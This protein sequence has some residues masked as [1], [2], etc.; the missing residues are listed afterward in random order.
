LNGILSIKIQKLNYLI[1]TFSKAL[2]ILLP[3]DENSMIIH[4]GYENLSLKH[5]FVTVGVFDGVHKGHRAL[6][7]HLAT[8]AEEAGGESVVITF[9][10]HPR[11][12]LSKKTEGIFFLSTLDEKKKLL[13]ESAIDHLI[14]MNFTRELGNMEAADFIKEILV[15]KIG[16]K[17]LIVGY[18][19][20]FGKGKEGD[21]EKI[22]EYAGLYDF[23]AEQADGLSAPEGKISSTIIR[24]A[25][26]NGRLEDANR[27]LGYN[28]SLTGNVIEGRK[29]GRSLGFPTANI[30]PADMFKLIPADGVYA[31]EV[32]TGKEKLPGMLSIGFNPTV[33]KN[34][35]DKSVEVHIFDFDKEL[36][37][38]T[39]TVIF[40][41]RL[42]DEKRFENTEQLTGQMK[43]DKES[44]MRLL[45]EQHH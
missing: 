23:E 1:I 25:L 41:F 33:N 45:A 20:H 7:D 9:D 24:D 21:F 6:L 8:R 3:Q 44:V 43:L 28:Y 12:V 31:V 14:I 11:L 34:R 18:D 27:L 29:L 42:R 16:V 17:H 26:L 40:R 5:P 4:E 15:E 35:A 13:A 32:L 10:P 2:L 37:G 30:K 38:Q 36:Y 39:I 22:R 19:N